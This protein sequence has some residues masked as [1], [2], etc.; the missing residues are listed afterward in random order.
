MQTCQKFSD[1]NEIFNN[2]TVLYVA[3][4]AITI[5]VFIYNSLIVINTRKNN[6]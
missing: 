3:L 6:L 1:S 4:D 2:G 5:I